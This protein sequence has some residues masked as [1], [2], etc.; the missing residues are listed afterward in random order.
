MRVG[1]ARD[2]PGHADGKSRIARQLR[3]W[4]PL[5]VEEHL[6]RGSRRRGLAIVDR[7][8][9]VGPCEPDQHEAAAAEVAG[10]R[11]RDRKRE[12]HRHR[13]IH[14]ISALPQ[15]LDAN[16]R[17]MGLFARHHAV[18]CSRDGRSLRLRRSARARK[19]DECN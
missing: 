2:R 12:T 7:R 10:L 19:N 16:A 6:A 8:H 9:A 1:K 4:I 18:S 5:L 13:R 17:R 11:Q 3:V 15:Y 14:G